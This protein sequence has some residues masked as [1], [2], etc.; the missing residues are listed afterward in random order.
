MHGRTTKVLEY[1]G[2]NGS[3]ATYATTNYTYNALDGLTQ[4][5]NQ[6]NN[7]TSIGYDALGRKRTMSDPD[8]KS[9]AYAYDGNGNLVRQDDAKN[10]RLCFYYDALNRIKGKLYQTTG[11]ACAGDPGAG[12]YSANYFYDEGSVGAL[13]NSRRTRMSNGNDTT[14]WTY[15]VRGRVSAETRTISA[16][17]FSTEFIY[18]AMDRVTT[19]TNPS[20]EAVTTR[21]NDAGQPDKLTSSQL[22]SSN[23]N[24]YVTSATYNAL[25][26]MT[27][28]VAGNDASAANRV[29]TDFTYSPTS[30]RL[31]QLRVG[32]GATT[33]MQFSYGYD[34]VGNVSSIFAFDPRR[35]SHLLFQRSGSIERLEDRH[36]ELHKPNRRGQTVVVNAIG[37]MTTKGGLTLN[38]APSGANSV[39]PHTVS[40]A[41][42]ANGTATFAYD[43]NGNMTTRVELSA[44]ERITYTQGWDAEN[45]L[46]T[47]TN[48][49]NRDITRFFYDADGKRV[50]RTDPAGTTLYVGD[51]YEVYTPIVMVPTATPTS[52]STATPTPTR[53]PTATSTATPTPTAT[54][55][56]TPT[57]TSTATATAT[58]T[59]T[60]T[61]TTGPSPTPTQPPPT[62]T[63]GPPSSLLVTCGPS[64]PS[65]IRSRKVAKN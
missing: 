39:R 24:D 65:A 33:Y 55:T 20:A 37:N 13:A 59:S 6:N 21:Y 10:Q 50:K 34:N 41:T 5:S 51:H 38:Y 46:T 11:A 16:T 62:A 61:P 36:T 43:D 57:P 3:E 17:N 52:T 47:V 64:C 56:Q 23:S 45:R 15:D 58:A 28:R 31:S 30:F 40:S 26:Q 42:S 44:T 7:V 1:T 35:K 53:T 29:T 19:I 54:A 32:V 12:N 4:V 48:A 63:P 8:M 60:S 27:Q 2:V 22:V 18:D 9:W 49:V 14:S 25:G